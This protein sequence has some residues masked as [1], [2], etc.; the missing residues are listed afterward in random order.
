MSCENCN[1]IIRNVIGTPASY[2][3]RWSKLNDTND[4]VYI[5]N[6]PITADDIRETPLEI[7][8]GGPG[9]ET[10]GQFWDGNSISVRFENFFNSDCYLDVS[11]SCEPAVTTTTVST[12]CCDGL[13]YAIKTTGTGADQP[14]LAGL[15][16]TGFA[17]GTYQ[18]TQTGVFEYTVDVQGTG[19][20]CYGAID[21][22]PG[23]LRS[24]P[25]FWSVLFMNRFNQLVKPTGD[26][27]IIGFP[28]AADGGS[29]NMLRP[30]IDN[31]NGNY[32]TY[33]SPSG[34]CFR[35]Q[36]DERNTADPVILREV[37]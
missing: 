3:I 32:V 13:E 2:K 35:G 15:S 4:I 24:T 27:Q 19:K 9:H 23:A 11:Y 20:L 26:E 28:S 25:L 33:V 21:Q 7:F 34:I 18:Y 31:N 8:A 37:V 22:S 5:N 29:V 36:L 10:L 12:D 30:W 1:I 16:T 14:P 6:G 17:A